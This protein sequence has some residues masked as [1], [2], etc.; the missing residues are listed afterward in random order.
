[1]G[2]IEKNEDKNGESQHQK[3]PQAHDKAILSRNTQVTAEDLDIKPVSNH[4]TTKMYDFLP[5][6]EFRLR[7]TLL[8]PSVLPLA[9]TLLT[10]TCAPPKSLSSCSSLS[11]THAT[12]TCTP[13][14]F[15]TLRA[16]PTPLTHLFHLHTLLISMRLPDLSA[17]VS[18]L[19][20]HTSWK[21]ASLPD[22]QSMDPVLALLVRLLVCGFNWRIRRGEWRGGRPSELELMCRSAVWKCAYVQGLENVPAWVDVIEEE[23][24]VYEGEGL[25]RLREVFCGEWEGWSG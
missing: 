3:Y 21:I 20:A 19:F 23:V 14:R 15:R 22:P 1:L 5:R 13:P 11:T 6:T 8:I 9:T 18:Y 4:T 12:L 25:G 10:R 7:H 17:T 2:F 24:G 16:P